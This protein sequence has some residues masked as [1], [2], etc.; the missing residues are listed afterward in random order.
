MLLLLFLLSNLIKIGQSCEAIR[1]PLCQTGINYNST[2]FPNLAGHLFQGGAS[3]GLRNIKS[4]IQ[5]QCSPNIREFLCRV[6]MPECSS[7]GKPVLPSWEMCQESYEGCD[8]LMSSL[9][10]SWNFSLN[11]TRFTGMCLLL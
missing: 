3:V 4:L 6:Y 11:C 1:E 9:G 8:T 10:Y 2:V 5:K 7:T